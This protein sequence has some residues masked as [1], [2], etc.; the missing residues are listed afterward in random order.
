VSDAAMPT[1]DRTGSE[2]KV[3]EL[4]HPQRPSHLAA[5]EFAERGCHRCAP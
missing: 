1:I 5:L 2:Y 4:C 3:K